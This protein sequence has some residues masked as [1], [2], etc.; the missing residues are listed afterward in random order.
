MPNAN[1]AEHSRGPMSKDEVLRYAENERRL[2]KL[3]ANAL[4][5]YPD[6]FSVEHV[7]TPEELTAAAL[8]HRAAARFLPPSKKD[9]IFFGQ[10]WIN[11][12]TTEMYT[13]AQVYRLLGTPFPNRGKI[14]LIGAGTAVP[15]VLGLSK[16][17]YVEDSKTFQ[18]ALDMTAE[19]YET[20][21]HPAMLLDPSF[22][23]IAD[24]IVEESRITEKTNPHLRFFSF[25]PN[26]KE[27]EINKFCHQY[28]SKIPTTV[29]FR[30]K[31]LDWFLD[32]QYA[33]FSGL[34][35]NRAD[36]E[37]VFDRRTFGP[38]ATAAIKAQEM[39]NDKLVESLFLSELSTLDELVQKLMSKLNPGG[40]CHVTVGQGN[41]VENSVEG[42]MRQVFLLLLARA[43][44][45]GNHCAR[46]TVFPLI[47]D[48]T[49]RS[50]M[51]QASLMCAYLEKPTSSS[52]K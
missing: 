48:R 15:E 6:I 20:V 35:W 44:I 4:T 36:P 12:F 29:N 10:H 27:H 16:Q 11:L 43:A 17:V 28:M 9:N 45:S 19:N 13:T 18:L 21:L 50:L 42:D 8:C 3:A 41:L 39:L 31:T 7:Q 49:V 23:T 34:V 51:P 32:S 1:D 46:T 2:L 52:R 33:G 24:A 25:D 40:A 47:H 22:H 5:Q 26:H 14:G 37:V 30:Q 38:K